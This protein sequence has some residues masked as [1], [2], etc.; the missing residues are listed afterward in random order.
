MGNLGFS[1]RPDEVP[2]SEYSGEPIP[3]GRY[4][5]VVVEAE[6]MDTKAGTGRIIKIKTEVDGGDYHGRVI[7]EQF[8]IANQSAQAQAIGLQQFKYFC[9]AIG[10]AQVD[11]TSEILFKPFFG[12]V[13]VDPAKGEFQAKN[14]IK[15]YVVI[16]G[17][18]TQMPSGSPPARPTTAPPPAQQA[19]VGSTAQSRPWGNGTAGRTP[20]HA[21]RP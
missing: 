17:V 2:E 4:R 6:V 12:E 5:L 9:N 21:N 19:A 18:G 11:D 7:W 20:A 14:F 1:F 8:N 16:A 15:K 13:R 3:A 10:L